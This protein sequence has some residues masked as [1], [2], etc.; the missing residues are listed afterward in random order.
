MEAFVLM[1][2]LSLI[3]FACQDEETVLS[4]ALEGTVTNALSSGSGEPVAQAVVTLVGAK[5]ESKTTGT[6]GRFLFENLTIGDYKVAVSHPDF[7]PAESGDITVRSLDQSS[8]DISLTPKPAITVSP[9]SLDFGESKKEISLSFKNVI[10]T[11]ISYQ[12]EAPSS[13][14]TTGKSS[15]TLQSQNSANIL[16]SV[17][18]SKME[19]GL[20]EA[21]LTVNVANRASVD[22]VVT[23]LNNPETPLEISPTQLDFGSD[24]DEKSLILK[25]T[26]NSAVSYEVTKTENWIKISKS[27]GTVNGL[28]QDN[29]S[30]TVD[31]TGLEEGDYSGAVIINIPGSGAIT[32]QVLMTKAPL[33]SMEINPDEID[34]GTGDNSK[35]VS[36]SNPNS[37]DITY[38]VEISADWLSVNKTSGTLTG[39]NQTSFTFT[40]DRSKLSIGSNQTSVSFK[41]QTAGVAVLGVLAEKVDASGAFIVIDQ[42][43][44]NFGE[45]TTSLDLNIQNTGSASLAWSANIAIDAGESWLSLSA[46]EGNVAASESEVIQVFVNR[47]GLVNGDYSAKLQFSGNGGDDEVQVIMT[48]NESGSGGG[49]NED[50]DNDGVVNS[51][52]ADDDNDGLIE[53]FTIE[54]LDA[55]RNDLDADGSSLAGAPDGGFTGYELVRDLNFEDS[56]SY[57]DASKKSSY[58]SG[59][60]WEPI[61]LSNGDFN[62]EFEGNGF[63]ISNLSIN[64]TSSNSALFASTTFRSEIRNINVTIK[65]LSGYRNTAGLIGHNRGDVLNCSVTGNASS[66]DYA[67]G[68]LV[69]VHEKGEISGCYS[70]G[71]VDSD[72][73]GVGG[74]IGYLGT[75]SSDEWKVEYSYSTAKVSG[76]RHTGGLIGYRYT[77]SGVVESCYAKGNVESTSQDVGGLI[78]SFSGGE[79]LSCYATGDVSAESYYV[80]G[81]VGNNAGTINTS[82]AI[83]AVE[84]SSSVGG[85]V[86]RNSGS[87]SSTNYWDMD[88][89]G[90]DTSAG[91]ATG[92]TTTTLQGVTSNTSIYTTWSS[93][94]WDF[95]NA[96][97]YP[98]LKDMPN[99]VDAQ[100]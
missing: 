72:G 7:E 5:S 49:G 43:T 56:D 68:L 61:G 58:T 38:A 81:L 26:I 46:A 57:K 14:I 28:N 51:V 20:N 16:V 69:G 55:I 19:L 24:E 53:I 84:G 85:L 22:L 99:G 37:A 50:D 10:S 27:T 54:D 89:S 97:Q 76:A 79:I 36:L 11:E 33:E 93:E 87:V 21:T 78:G 17:D 44:M 83:G 90:V 23:A 42:T 74:L 92:Q 2:L 96:S 3:I 47:A 77:G 29:L 91:D 12:I 73:Y 59:S 66:T 40:V 25:N 13:W 8:V 95:G 34:F 15:G 9:S 94:A 18:R 6:D 30:V 60:G 52:D 98:A 86:G 80:G 63:T 4:G 31:K 65:F 1:L 70:S 35:E 32:V 62:A 67:L 39:K 71:V 41:S 64:R 82:Y 75:R 88:A 45:E 100:R 48:V